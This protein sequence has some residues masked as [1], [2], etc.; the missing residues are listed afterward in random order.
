MKKYAF[1]IDIGKCENCQNCFL[2]CKDEHCGNAW[3]GYSRPQPLHGQRWLDILQ[4]ERGSFPLIDVAYLPKPCMHCD[5]APCVAAG[6][7]VVYQRQDGIVIIDPDKARGRR[8]L[9][10]SCPHGAIFWNEEEGVAQKCTLC[11]HLLDGGWKAPRCVQS[12]PTG[13]LVLFYGPE[14]E[15]RKRIAQERLQILPA[16]QDG[17]GRPRC[18]YKNLYRYS[19]CFLA[20]SLAEQVSG[21]EECVIGARLVL[22][23]GDEVIGEQL[24]DDFGDFKFDDLPDDRADCEL[25]ILLGEKEVKRQT[26][27]LSNGQS[28]GTIRINR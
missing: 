4:K 1:I 19:R 26:V 28:V 9:V 11:A 20:G 23:R 27:T 22:Q 17:P 21:V 10:S 6:D 12:C 18:Y 7:G 5:Q 16:A 24:S 13:A 3:P 15:L 2:S 14:E 8:D 25:V